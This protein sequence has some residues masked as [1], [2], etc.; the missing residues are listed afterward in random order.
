VTGRAR[1]RLA[2]A[3]LLPVALAACGKRGPPVAPAQR[4][5]AT[6]QDLTAVTSGEGVR[7]AWTLPRIRVDRSPLKDLRRTEIYRRLEDGNAAAPPRP[8]ILTF[9]GLFGGPSGVAGFERIADI[10]LDKPE[11]AEVKGSQVAYTDAQGVAFGRRYTYVVI[12]IDDQGRPSAPSNQVAVA[13]VAPPRSPTGLTAQAGDGQIRLTWSPPATLEDGNAAPDAL[14]YNVFRT[15]T[16]AAASGRPLNLE[17]LSSP[18]YVDLTVQNDTTYA[19]SVRAFTALGQPPSRP[20]EVVNATPEDTTAPAQPR[21]L[22]SV[23]A[24]PTVRLAWEAVPDADVMGYVVYRTL[25]PGRGYEK[26][27]PSPQAP[28]TYVDTGVRPGQ[29]YYYVVTAVDRSHRANESVPS[30]EAAARI[31]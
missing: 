20:S 15:A 21:G 10:S 9:G 28:T 25:T 4:L 5:P 27:T 6:I 19:Y 11:P 18:Q 13:S 31:P 7:L 8:A 22:V 17:P 29:T 2:L 12:A 3:L 1:A 16:A 23:V 26:L 14:L 30:A 24:G